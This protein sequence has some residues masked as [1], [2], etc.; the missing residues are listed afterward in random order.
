[1]LKETNGK[2][3]FSFLRAVLGLKD[4]LIGTVLTILTHRGDAQ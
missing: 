2:H 1:M 4:E 3:L